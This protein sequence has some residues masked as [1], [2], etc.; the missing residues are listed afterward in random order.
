MPVSW[1]NDDTLAMTKLPTLKTD[2][3]GAPVTETKTYTNTDTNI[4]TKPAETPAEICQTQVA[5]TQHQSHPNTTETVPTQEDPRIDI[6]WVQIVTNIAS[7]AILV[8]PAV[9][10]VSDNTKDPNF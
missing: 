4:K 3:A 7:T 5:P 10:L 2:N 8:N 1:H 9:I 6:P